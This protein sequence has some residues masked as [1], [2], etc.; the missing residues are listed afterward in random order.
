MTPRDHAGRFPPGT[1]GNPAGRRKGSRSRSTI[2]A[3]MLLE[4]QAKQLAQKAVD[5]AL[6][7]DTTMLKLTIERL[8]PRKHER[9]VSIALPAVSD[10]KQAAAALAAIVKGVG[11]GDLTPGE[12]KTLVALVEAAIKTVEAVDHEKRLTAL[13]ERK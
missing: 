4:G 11:T 8:I 2:M 5:M 13:E 6:A 12:A 9:P 7:G 1:S 3:E 10:P